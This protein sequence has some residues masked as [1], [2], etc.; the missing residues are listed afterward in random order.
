MSADTDHLAA[1]LKACSW[2]LVALGSA[3][4]AWLWLFPPAFV[5]YLFLAFAIRA[6]R[7]L[8]VRAVV[9]VVSLGSVCAGFF[10]YWDASFIHLSSH[11][12]NPLAVVV[13]ESLLAVATWLVVRRLEREVI[14][15]HAAS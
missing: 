4:T 9:L 13:I 6:S 8:V 3:M 10:V 1:T 11:N 7:R 14:Q 15:E 5:P 12:T 2:L